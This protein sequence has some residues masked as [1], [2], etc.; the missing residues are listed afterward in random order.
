MKEHA[1]LKETEIP[2]FCWDRKLTTNQIKEELNTN[3]P[4][5]KIKLLAWIMREARFSDIWQF[6]SPL[7]VYSLFKNLYPLLGRQRPFWNYIINKW[8][9][10]GK[11]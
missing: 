8:Y 2:Y 9:E 4:S 7:E 11:I 10:L 1:S 3:N 5:H 6:T